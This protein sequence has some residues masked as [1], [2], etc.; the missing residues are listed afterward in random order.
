[1]GDA[2]LAYRW[3]KNGMDISDD[4]RI[5]GSTAAALMISPVNVLDAGNYQV[6]VTN[7]L[8]GATSSVAALTILGPPII[9]TQPVSKESKPWRI[10]KVA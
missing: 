4:G 8:G 2:P 5:T 6:F 1:L 9:S 7:S 10:R 3:Q